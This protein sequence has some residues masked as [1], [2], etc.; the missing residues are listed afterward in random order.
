LGDFDIKK[1][2]S[3]GINLL[4]SL[5]AP[6][7]ALAPTQAVWKGDR[8][9]S[10]CMAS[11]TLY[12]DNMSLSSLSFS[13]A[14]TENARQLGIT[15]HDIINDHAKSPFCCPVS[16][17]T[18]TCNFG[19]AEMTSSLERRHI[20]NIEDLYKDIKPDL[21]L[22]SPNEHSASSMLGCF[23]LAEF[24]SKAILAASMNPP[25]ID[26]DIFVLI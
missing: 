1:V 14:F 3:S 4:A 5:D 9:E 18:K 21:A 20:T 16:D 13:A 25:L 24:R 8:A 15:P 6:I 10:I 17:L 19:L 23:A 11:Q 12:L 26:E 22:H 2:F 7:E